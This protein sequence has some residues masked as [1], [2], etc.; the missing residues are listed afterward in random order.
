MKL[1][2]TPKSKT[3]K[4]KMVKNVPRLEFTEVVLIHCNIINNDYQN[5]TGVFY[6]FFLI[7]LVINYYIFHLKNSYI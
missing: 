6:N 4:M 5:D 1:I 7:N 2:R 3:T